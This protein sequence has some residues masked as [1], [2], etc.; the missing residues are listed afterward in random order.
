MCVWLERGSVRA[1]AEDVDV[2]FAVGDVIVAVIGHRVTPC[3][4]RWRDRVG[5]P[6]HFV[7]KRGHVGLFSEIVPIP[8]R[9]S[10]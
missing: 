1:A 10:Y 5:E 2:V 8:R 3:D 6:F 4:Q 7:I 9:S